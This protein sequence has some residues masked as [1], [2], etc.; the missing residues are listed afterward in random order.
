MSVYFFKLEKSQEKHN[1][2][3]QRNIEGFVTNK[4]EEISKFKSYLSTFLVYFN[5]IKS[6]S[7]EDQSFC[8]SSITLDEIVDDITDLENNKSPG[9]DGITSEFYKIF[10]SYLYHCSLK[11]SQQL[12]LC[13][14]TCYR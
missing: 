11:V 10:Q 1:S 7:Q 12:L 5:N 13:R 8:D 9:N 14:L 2:I 3:F 4:P 6:I